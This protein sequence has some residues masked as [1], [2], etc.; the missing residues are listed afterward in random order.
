MQ[1]KNKANIISR[2]GFGLQVGSV[3]YLSSYVPVVL[4]DSPP[5]M[6]LLRLAMYRAYSCGSRQHL[7]ETPA[8]LCRRRTLVPQHEVE[9]AGKVVG[10]GAAGAGIHEGQEEGQQQQSEEEEPERKSQPTHT[11]QQAGLLQ[12]QRHTHQG[13]VAPRV[14][15]HRGRHLFLIPAHIRST[16][17]SHTTS[18]SITASPTVI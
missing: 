12:R 6:E 11:L 18:C 3:C 1:E 10:E 4:Q 7:E 9:G 5:D 16:G 14:R 2:R 8:S 17:S 15:P 13:S